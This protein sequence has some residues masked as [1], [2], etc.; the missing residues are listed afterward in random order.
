[1]D[2]E[3]EASLLL[4]RLSSAADKICGPHGVQ[5][6]EHRA[7][8]EDLLAL[9]QSLLDPST[10]SGE[11]GPLHSFVFFLWEPTKRKENLH[12]HEFKRTCRFLRSVSPRGVVLAWYKLLSISLN[13]GVGTKQGERRKE[14][15]R[16][17]ALYD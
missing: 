10:P 5:S 15:S 12:G 7:H 13:F 2:S 14:G 4:D 16:L 3:E 6:A 8:D 17:V 11:V 1:M 9:A